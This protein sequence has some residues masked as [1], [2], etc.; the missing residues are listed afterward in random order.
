MIAAWFDGNGMPDG[1]LFW[2]VLA[3][4]LGIAVVGGVFY[5]FSTFVMQ[6][7]RRLPPHEG[8][9][10]MQSINIAVINPLFLG[11]FLGTALLCVVVTIPA[12]SRHRDPGTTYLLAGSALSLLGTFGVTI[13][14]N[15]PLNNQL[16]PL[17]PNAPGA[18]YHWA[19]YVSRWT[20]WNH[21]RTIAA[22]L[23]AAAFILAL[24]R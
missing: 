5:A 6:A 19:R 10:A 9:A 18:P 14:C 4:A 8:I 12:L 15:V 2:L 23:A 7:L 24:R 17:Q 1:W 3:A 13:A 21:V 16:A 11:L 20:A 22:L